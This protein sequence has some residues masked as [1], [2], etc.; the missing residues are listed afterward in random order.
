MALSRKRQ[1]FTLIELLVVIAII[2]IL[3]A[4]L[5]PVFA[6][7]REAARRANCLSNAK[8]I[9]LA[10]IM[11]ANDYDETMPAASAGCGNNNGAAHPVNGYIQSVCGAAAGCLSDDQWDVCMGAGQWKIADMAAP[12]VKNDG[13]FVCPTVKGYISRGPAY[14][15]DSKAGGKM[16]DSADRCDDQDGSYMWFCGHTTAP[17]DTVTTPWPCPIVPCTGV[18]ATLENQ[19]AFSENALYAI[20]LIAKVFGVVHPAAVS[21]YYFACS[22]PMSRFA[23]AGGVAVAICNSY[24]AH[25]GYDPDSS[26]VRCKIFPPELKSIM[27]TIAPTFCQDCVNNGAFATVNDCLVAGALPIATPF[28]FAD[29]HVKYVRGDFYYYLGTA[30]RPLGVW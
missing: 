7:A 29:G 12:Y 16:D 5:F 15:I 19:C 2:A 13:V 27:M 8:Q 17:Q 10:V 25:E 20:M 24:G 28:A 21:D 23:D 22:N 9:A 18:I 4:I 30:V 3:A 6:R 14:G 1:G 11:Y 26:V